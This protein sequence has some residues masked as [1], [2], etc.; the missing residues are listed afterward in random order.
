MA[1]NGFFKSSQLTSKKIKKGNNNARCGEC[2][3][4]KNCMNPKMSAGGRG[5]L[6][7]LIVAE[8]PGPTEDKRNEQL[9]GKVGKFLERKLRRT[10]KIE[11]NDCKKTNAV[12]CHPE[13]NATPNKKQIKAC[14]PNL[15]QTIN[16]FQPHVII[17]LGGVALDALIGHKFDQDIG[18]INKWRGSI[19]PDREYKAWICPTFHPSYVTRETSPKAAEIIFEQ[20]LYDATSMLDIQLPDRTY[21][22]LE[23]KV[24][25]LKHHTEVTHWLKKLLYGEACLTAFDFETTGLKPQRE[26]QRIKTCAIADSPD[27]VVAFPMVQNK[28]FRQMLN[29]YFS[30]LHIRKII[31]NM[32]YER[33]W[34][35]AFGYKLNEVYFDTMIG[36]HCL[37]NRPGITGLEYQNY[38]NFGIEPYDSTV[39]QYIKPKG[40]KGNDLNYIHQADLRDVLIYNG[41]DSITELRQGIVMMDRFG[42]DYSHLYNDCDYRDF[43]P[44]YY[45]VEQN[46]DKK[47]F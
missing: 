33:D 7:I 25:I 44:Q 10:C 18:G 39:K 35:H 22:D 47:E 32:K 36:A 31:A 37:D 42:I 15:Q 27:H 41:L 17:P 2:G 38:V 12:I 29:R 30:S 1:K 24:E 46:R 21:E 26:E 19:I 28:E 23:S 4:Y 3:L 8:A 16:E 40:M 34:C 11:L 43:A 5:V 13:N 14:N 6:K 20:D 9:V 45:K